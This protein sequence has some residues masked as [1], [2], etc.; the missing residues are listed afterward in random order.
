MIT[1]NQLMTQNIKIVMTDNTTN[2]IFP[3]TLLIR[4]EKDGLVWQVYHVQKTIEAY[5]LAN[6]ATRNGYEDI[7]LE[8]Y[9]PE[10]EES[11]PDWRGSE[12]GKAIITAE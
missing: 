9:N 1:I 12:G 6:T 11:Y 2:S 8:D 4:N 10:Y 3:K 5:R 7:R